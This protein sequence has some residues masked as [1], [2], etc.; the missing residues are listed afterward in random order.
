MLSSTG[1]RNS[2]TRSA[3]ASALISVKQ[4]TSPSLCQLIRASLSPARILTMLRSSLGKTICPRSSTTR[5]SAPSQEQNAGV[6]LL[7]VFFGNLL[8]DFSGV[9]ADLRVGH[10]VHSE[11]VLIVFEKLI[12]EYYFGFQVRKGPFGQASGARHSAPI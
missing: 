12:G 5:H 8:C 10:F 3:K 7:K 9:G 4:Q 1:P 2:F 11:E 6:R